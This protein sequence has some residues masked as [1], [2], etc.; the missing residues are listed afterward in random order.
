MKAKDVSLLAII[1]AAVWVVLLTLGRAV[2]PAFTEQEFGLSI[3]EIIATGVF[4]VVIFS[5]IYRSIW[6]DKKLQLQSD[7]QADSNNFVEKVMGEL[8]E[9][10]KEA[11]N[12]KTLDFAT[13][14]KTEPVLKTASAQNDEQVKTKS[15]G[16]KTSSATPES[17][18]IEG[19]AGLPGV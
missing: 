9:I 1:F 2:F 19:I 18:G 4:F 14:L 3:P 13:V 6:L 7:M 16:K 17:V 15:K 8:S 10:V 12:S 11:N 5:P